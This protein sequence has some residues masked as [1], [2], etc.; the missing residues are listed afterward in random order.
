MERWLLTYSDMIT[1]LL[2]LFVI[3]FALSTINAKKFLAFKLGIT[4]TFSENPVHMQDKSG[5]LPQQ[6]DLAAHPVT[7][8]LSPS[9]PGTAL[10]TSRPDAMAKIAHELHQALQTVG[11]SQDVSIT[12][13][14]RSVVVQVLADKVY[15]AVDSAT[16][17]TTGD[18]VVDTIAGVLRTLPNPVRVEGFTDNQ[19]II[20]GPFTS[21]WELSAVRAV[22]VVRRLQTQDGIA[23]TRLSAIGYGTTHPVV[24]NTSP[25]NQ[26][27]N[28]RIDVVVL[29]AKLASPSGTPGSTTGATA[30]SRC[31][32]LWSSSRSP[33]DR[34]SE[35]SWSRLPPRQSIGAS[36]RL[37]RCSRASRR[38]RSPRS[39]P[40]RFRAPATR[41]ARRPPTGSSRTHRR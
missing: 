29:T 13:T 30:S 23:A 17:G 41:R 25:A 36:R 1:L 10:P 8:A 20:G 19:P 3:L 28:R 16:L 18:Q 38:P 33:P 4:Q 7:T 12:A 34:S 11:L 2:A 35:R 14:S 9:T 24:P 31:S 37:T 21:N 32:S 27:E 26:A 39:R 5:L 6:N 22:N 40:P 15:F